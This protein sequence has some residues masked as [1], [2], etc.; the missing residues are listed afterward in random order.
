LKN[1]ATE[2]NNVSLE[3]M[4]AY[5]GGNLSEKES[6]RLRA[7]MDQ[8]PLLVEALGELDLHLKNGGSAENAYSIRS[9]IKEIVNKNRPKRYAFLPMA[10][11]ATI[12]V[13][14]TVLFTILLLKND[15]NLFY[16]Y[17]QPYADIVSTRGA[18]IPE[19]LN[20]AIAAY[21]RENYLQAIILFE[22]AERDGEVKNIASFYKGQSY[23]AE[24]QIN[25]AIKILNVIAKDDGNILQSHAQWYL[26]LA[27]LKKEDTVTSLKYLDQLVIDRNS[28][29]SEKA[30]ELSHR[31]RNR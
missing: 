19:S 16:E 14:F 7:A 26:A 15:E 8:D 23:L 1:K 17:Y 30:V 18:D 6:Q 9:I 3:E 28:Y 27:Y 21:N 10:V 11:A 13:L 25:E 24:E 29:N 12:I 2:K 22:M 31:I 5:L 20:N 4:I